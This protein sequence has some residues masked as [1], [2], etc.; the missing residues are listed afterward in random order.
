MPQCPEHGYRPVSDY[1]SSC[2]CGDGY[3]WAW[4]NGVGGFACLPCVDGATWDPQQRCGGAPRRAAG[5]LP[6]RLPAG[7][8]LQV[9]QFQ[10][11]AAP[12]FSV[13]TGG[14]RA[15]FP[16]SSG[17]PPPSSNPA[18]SSQR[19][20]AMLS[21][22]APLPPPP[23]L[24]RPSGPAFAP[25]TGTAPTRATNAPLT[26]RRGA[27]TCLTLTSAVGRLAC[28]GQAV[29]VVGTRGSLFPAS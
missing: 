20:P 22:R 21:L 7:W 15:N 27:A 14:H 13:E 28:A 1:D 23:P 12:S 8:W 26:A 5:C 4:R 10:R 19:F 17:L 16:A 3:E 29:L 24:G 18:S 11:V 25:A 6:G 2:R 9:Q